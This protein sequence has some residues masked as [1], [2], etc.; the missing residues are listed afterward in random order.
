LD[1]C[2]RLRDA[3]LVHDVVKAEVEARTLPQVVRNKTIDP[4]SDKENVASVVGTL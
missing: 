2:S 3:D 1:E 4:L